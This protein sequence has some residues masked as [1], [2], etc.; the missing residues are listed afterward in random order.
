M[1]VQKLLPGFEGV[2]VVIRQPAEAMRASLAREMAYLLAS[3]RETSWGRRIAPAGLSHSIGVCLIEDWHM[4]RGKGK[5]SDKQGGGGLPTFIDVRLSA[6]DRENFLAFLGDDFDA[7]RVLQAFA[8]DG[9]RVG[10]TWS[11]EHQTYTVSATCRN[12]ESENMGLCMTAFS[13]DLAQGIL[14]LWF[15]H[16]VVCGRQWR[17]FEPKPTE[18]FG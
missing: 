1:S 13:R 4:A 5:A 12:E 17:A 11:G 15:K 6:E 3:S 16:D 18:R 10:V 9:Y 2:G 8:D 7:V 14:L